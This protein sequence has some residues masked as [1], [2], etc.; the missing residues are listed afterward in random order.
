MTVYIVQIVD[1]E[2]DLFD[3]FRTEGAAERFIKAFKRSYKHLYHAMQVPETRIRK[4][5]VWHG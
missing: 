3:V 5:H 1:I 4:R 2:G